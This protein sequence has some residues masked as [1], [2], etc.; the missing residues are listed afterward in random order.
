MRFL[1][2]S[3]T[4]DSRY[5][6]YQYYRIIELYESYGGKAADVENVMKRH[7]LNRDQLMQ[8]YN[9]FYNGG[10]AAEPG[11]GE[12]QLTPEESAV[13]VA[14]YCEIANELASRPEGDYAA[15]SAEE[16]YIDSLLWMVIDGLKEDPEA[17]RLLET[18]EQYKKLDRERSRRL[19]ND[20]VSKHPEYK[21]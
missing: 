12:P 8:Y 3:T 14:K 21:K 1:N 10:S 20:F 9:A 15:A 11:D 5:V 19:W 13:E 4:Y 7:S 2:P 16:R 17:M 6:P 18:N